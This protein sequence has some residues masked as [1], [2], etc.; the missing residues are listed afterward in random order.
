MDS[1]PCRRG[2]PDLRI[3]T[4]IPVTNQFQFF[5][6]GI[7]P[8]ATSWRAR[9]I[10][11]LVWPPE[12]S[13]A[14]SAAL[15]VGITLL[16]GWLYYFAEGTVS[17]QVF[18]LVPMIL[19]LSWLGLGWGIAVVVLSA[20]LRL[21]GDLLHVGPDF[22]TATN[23]LRMTSQ[24]V[25]S[26]SVYLVVVLVIH[27]LFKL[28]RQLEQRV[29]T[30]TTALRQAVVARERLQK[31]L[32]EVG[33]RERGAIGRDL[34]DGL[35]QHL[36]AT[37]M[38]TSILTQRLA[39]RGDP[40]ADDARK[41]EALI[42]TAIEQTRQIARGLLLEN[43]KPDELVSEL[44][45][46]AADATHQHRTP[47]MFTAEGATDHLDANIASHLFYIAREAVGNALRHGGA[48]RIAIHFSVGRALVALSVTDNGRGLAPS[49]PADGGMGLRIMSERAELIG[50]KLRIDTAPGVGTRVDCHVPLPATA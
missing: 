46:L 38:A 17:L 5:D 32:F 20:F 31:N 49:A 14:V 50:G 33:L 8:P 22:F 9:I 36:T 48:S 28:N 43:V 21:F 34:H 27:E 3:F 4:I 19:A 41:A 6:D 16:I 30:R 1:A 40:L 45:E 2:R 11:A 15:S 42:K 7:A 47:C 12:R 29:Q 35:G 18:Y 37:A 39:A 24:R 26:L 13:R 23:T 44:E 10:A 25:S